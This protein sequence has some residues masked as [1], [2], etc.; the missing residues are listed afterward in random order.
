[1]INEK[2]DSIENKI[3]EVKV[4]LHKL[5]LGLTKRVDRNTLILNIIIKISIVLFI[6]MVGSLFALL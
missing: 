5:E 1:M 3:D 2:L 6:A 4:D